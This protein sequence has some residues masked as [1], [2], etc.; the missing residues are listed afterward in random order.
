MEYNYVQLDK[1]VDGTCKAYY[2][3]DDETT[4][5]G[6]HVVKTVILKDVTEAKLSLGKWDSEVESYI[7]EAPFPEWITK[8]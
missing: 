1:P 8:P 5:P 3:L 4:M 7:Y 2:F 6:G